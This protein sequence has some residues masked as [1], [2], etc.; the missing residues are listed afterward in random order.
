MMMKHPSPRRL[1][2][3]AACMLLIGPVSGCQPESQEELRGSL[4][5]ASGQYLAQLDLRD[6]STSIVTNL[7]DV[8]IRAISPQR[9]A[10]LLLTVFGAVNQRDMYRLVLYDI[11]TRQAL[12]LLNGRNG[13]YLPD[14]DTLVYDD[15]AQIYVAERR[16]REWEKTAVLKH[17]YNAALH[18]TPITDTR[19][20]YAVAGG[21]VNLFDLESRRAVELTALSKLCRLDA[22]LWSS[23]R[24]QLL[25]R[26][27]QGNGPHEYAFSNL[28]GE[29]RA[30]LH[31][32]ASRSLQ[33][34]A[35][36]PDQDA[37]VFTERWRSAFSDRQKHAVWIYRFDS[38]A[39]YRLIDNQHLGP[40]VVYAR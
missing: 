2:F 31:L 15:G 24:E 37:V 39:L 8:E 32:P 1:A 13:H 36:L 11:A 22:S 33:P 4:Y 7:G 35:F 6:G 38:G 14:S 29:V 3:V 12:T 18:V 20:L 16:D 27:D 28:D 17:S 21:P 40:T 26:I 9:D 25:C 34:V 30:T 5:F 19:F 10:R 23:E